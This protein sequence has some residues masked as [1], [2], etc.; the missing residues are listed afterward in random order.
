MSI[1]KKARLGFIGAGWWATSNHMPL[2]A[3]REDVE[4]V[5]VCR[6]G[7]TELA[8]VKER[9][10]FTYATED[11]H[12][13][14]ANCELDG[15]V[16]ASPHTLHHQHASAALEAGLHVMCEKPMTTR[17]ADARDL[18]HLAEK[19]NRQLVVPYGWHHKPFI[20]RAKALMDEGAI[21]EIEFALCHMASPI[22]ALLSGEELAA[23]D[24][25]DAS[26]QDSDGLFGPTP[27]TWAD[28][29]I[30][31]G[32][33]AH[34]QISHSSGL[35]FWLSGLRA[36]H[37]FAAMSAP[38]SQVELYDALTVRFSSG[39]IGTVSGAGTVPTDQTFQ[40]DLRLF[41]SEGMLLIDCERARMNLRRHDGRHTVEEVAEDAG[42][43]ECSGPPDNFADLILGKTDINVTPGEA[44]MRGVEMLDAAYRSAVSGR[45]E[46]V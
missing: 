14:L 6:L 42:A 1:Q 36:E 30:A 9:F 22:R 23:D 17:A 26:G 4:L 44:A 28:P 34:A 12:D 13:L 29:E 8:Q 41:G 35:L 3:A 11:Y 37:V 39:A 45:E 2:F 38:G 24:I 19:H 27:A 43:Y 7:Q 18:V 10:G 20:Q 32:G 33:Y 31:G 5:A 40:V 15:V 46:A 16:I 25:A 21:G